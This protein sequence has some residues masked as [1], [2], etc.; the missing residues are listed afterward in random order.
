MIGS[1]FY[2]TT[3]LHGL[4]VLIGSLVFYLIYFIVYSVPQRYSPRPL[5]HI[6]INIILLSSFS[7][8]FLFN[9]SIQCNSKFYVSLM[10]F[11]YHNLLKRGVRIAIRAKVNDCVITGLRVVDC[12]IPVGRGQRLINDESA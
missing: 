9:T 1:S 11:S 12:I 10:S 7:P 2:L 3:G 8:L 5:N 4:H 6:L